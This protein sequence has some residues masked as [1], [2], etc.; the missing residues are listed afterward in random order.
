MLLKS[1]CLTFCQPPVTSHLTFSNRTI[2]IT[3][4]RPWNLHVIW[5]R[6]YSLP[7]PSSSQI[8]K[9]HLHS[10]PLSVTPG[11]QLETQELL[12]NLTHLIL[13]L[14]TLRLNYTRLN[15]YSLPPLTCCMAT[16]P[17]PPTDYSFGQVDLTQ[18]SWIS[19]CLALDFWVALYK[20]WDYDYNGW[21]DVWRDEWMDVFRQLYKLQQLNYTLI[22]NNRQ[23]TTSYN[24]LLPRCETS[25][26][27]LGR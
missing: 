20:F 16:G 6:T 9:H 13:F 17:E 15:A 12:L 27:P 22:N 8:I 19:W 4:L 11:F 5:N 7:P 18:S 21:V 1:S 3:A 14:P 25:P 2:S 23:Q 26:R 24:R 10:A